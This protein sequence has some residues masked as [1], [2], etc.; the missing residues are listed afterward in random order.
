MAGMSILN[1]S[2]DHN[3]QSKADPKRVSLETRLFHRLDHE[4]DHAEGS[5]S[6]VIDLLR[7]NRRVFEPAFLSRKMIR[8]VSD[9]SRQHNMFNILLGLRAQLHAIR[10][11]VTPIRLLDASEQTAKG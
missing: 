7:V 6:E 4:M 10:D 3:S 5:Y 1:G 9:T 8:E 2:S 11:F